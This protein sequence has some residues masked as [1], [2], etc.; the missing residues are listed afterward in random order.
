MSFNLFI[1]ILY[2]HNKSLAITT[3][4]TYSVWVKLKI[5]YLICHA[6]SVLKLMITIFKQVF[7][8]RNNYFKQLDSLYR[9]E[10]N[11]HPITFLSNPY[12]YDRRMFVFSS[13][14]I[15]DNRLHYS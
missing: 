3:L 1:R 5:V 6:K 9:V 15:Q 13:M 7:L 12:I 14:I 8:F 2:Y 11:K 4:S 10:M